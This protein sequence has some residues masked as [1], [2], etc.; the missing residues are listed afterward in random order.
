MLTDPTFYMSMAQDESSY[1]IGIYLFLAVGLLMFIVGFLG[2]C[3]AIKESQCM[4]VLVSLC[5]DNGLG[6]SQ[7]T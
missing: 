1:Y 4:L 2:C 7:Y 5:L 6:L 3:G